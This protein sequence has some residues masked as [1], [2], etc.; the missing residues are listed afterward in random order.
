MPGFRKN[1]F[2]EGCEIEMEDL[3]RR[4]G[5]DE[6]ALVTPVLTPIPTLT[7]ALSVLDGVFLADSLNA[8]LSADALRIAQVTPVGN[9]SNDLA[10]SLS[11]PFYDNNGTNLNVYYPDPAAKSDKTRQKIYQDYLLRGI[12]KKIHGR[13]ILEMIVSFIPSQLEGEPHDSANLSLMGGPT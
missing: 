9:S 4:G 11:L 1:G 8:F 3:S 6:I 12:T 5:S 2:E 10:A 7:P 13:H